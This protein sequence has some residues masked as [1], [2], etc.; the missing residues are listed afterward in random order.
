MIDFP[1]SP[2]DG[3]VFNAPN[4]VVYKY[5]VAYTS[6]LAQNPTPP[7]GGSGAVTATGGGYTPAV[8]ADVVIPFGTVLSG[9][10]GLWWNTATGRYTPPAGKYFLS[11]I[12]ATQAPS[13]GNGTWTLKPRKNGVAIPGVG[14]SSSG[15]A[16]F[17]I[18]ISCGVYVDANGTDYFDWVANVAVAGMNAQ[19]GTFS[20]F[21]LTGMQGPTGGAPG[22]VTGDFTAMG[23]PA[24]SSGGNVMIMPV[25]N[26]NSGGYYNAT[27][28]RWTPPAGRY[29]FYAAVFAYNNTAG[30]GITAWLRK[31][32]VT[33]GQ[34]FSNNTPGANAWGFCPVEMQVDANGTDYFELVATANATG[35]QAYMGAFP[36][37]GM[38]GPQ[39]PQ[40]PPGGGPPNSDFYATASG[41]WPTATTVLVPA[42]NVVGNL[43]SY[44]NTSTGRYTPPAG[45]YYLYAWSSTGA[46][47]GGNVSVALYFYKNGALLPGQ[48][49]G[50]YQ[51]TP[52]AGIA[53]SM[54]ATVDANGTDFF[55][56]RGASSAAGTGYN[57]GFGAYS[58]QGAPGP[59]GPPGVIPPNALS[60]YQ[61]VVL[62]ANA[63]QM[64]VSWPTGAR[65]I[66]IEYMVMN[67]GNALDTVGFRA[68]VNGV[69][70][71]TAGYAS[72]YVY[73]TGS[74]AVG[75]QTI[76]Q[77]QWQALGGMI[78]TK[79]TFKPAVAPAPASQAFIEHTQVANSATAGYALEAFHWNMGAGMNGIQMFNNSGTMWLPGSFLRV[80]VV[81]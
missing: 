27:T 40:G 72:Q 51:L 75:G 49:V 57:I 50:T 20:A 11:C 74:S 66:E 19:G 33:L 15:G 77:N 30:I 45:R 69:P 6:W 21:P 31:N 67:A 63:N 41:T 64:S 43:G 28:G 26:G 2:I 44:Y 18:P 24:L 10:E 23:T 80:Y 65:K 34:T 7:L 38:V 55:D 70:N 22:T 61:E 56:L 3:Q 53:A 35:S 48:T 36:T 54:A 13:G 1:A 81:P 42:S 76:S 37:Q 79:G 59:Q 58:T 16:L 39:G 4:G 71:S 5:S 62:A 78:N 32:G 73:G 25:V 52:N 46:P 12:E 17:S 60:L 14:A 9:N 8:G 47:G 68:M 29:N